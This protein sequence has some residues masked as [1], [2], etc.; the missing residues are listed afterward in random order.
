MNTVSI[1]SSLYNSTELYARQH[2][3]TIEEA[4]ESGLRLLLNQFHTTKEKAK[5][6]WDTDE[7][8]NALAHVRSLSLKGGQPIPSDEDGREARTEKYML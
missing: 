4:V 3:I 5:S 1:N 6:V 7:Y 2:H 8:K